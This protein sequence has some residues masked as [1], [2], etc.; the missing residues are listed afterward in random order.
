MQRL[1]RLA[2]RLRTDRALVGAGVVATVVLA[3][4]VMQFALDYTLRLRLD[5][6]CALLFVVLGLIGWMTWRKLIQPQRLKFDERDIARVIEKRFPQLDSL[7]ISAVEFDSGRVGPASSNSPQLA[8]SV[9]QQ[10]VE[11]TSGLAFEDVIEPR[12]AR[13]GT[14]KII[15]VMVVCV[16]SFALAPQ[17][18]GI[19]LDRNK[20][21][22][23]HV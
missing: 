2:R 7:L 1:T 6:R 13:R 4:L 5:M 22:R 16:A 20:I 18:M 3:V 19:W 10:A 23:A 11:A 15:A 8:E 21:G 17:T 9:V 14:M 12:L